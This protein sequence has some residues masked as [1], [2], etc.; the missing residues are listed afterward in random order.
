MKRPAPGK[1]AARQFVD[2]M[3]YSRL[4]GPVLRC[5]SKNRQKKRDLLQPKQEQQ[6]QQ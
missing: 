5:E 6:Q 1:K 2:L 3:K 4:Y